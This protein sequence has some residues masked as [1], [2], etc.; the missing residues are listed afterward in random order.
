MHDAMPSK[1]ALGREAKA[2][3]V[4]SWNKKQKLA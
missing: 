4:E 2:K 1:T 3:V